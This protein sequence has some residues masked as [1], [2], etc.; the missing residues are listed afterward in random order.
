MSALTRVPIGP[1]DP[2]AVV[3]LS[4]A[5][6]EGP[7]S[8]PLPGWVAWR[9]ADGPRALVKRAIDLA[10]AVA[11]LLLLAPVMLLL[12]VLIRLDS[13]GPALFRQWRRG[14]GGRPFR[15]LK[16]RTMVADAERRLGD[17][18]SDNESAG[19]V[20]FKLRDDPRVTRLGRFLRRS[21]LDELPQLINVLRG[22]MS[23]VGPRPLQLRDCERLAAVDPRGYRHRL[24]VP[25]GLT[26]P[27]QVEGQ[28]ALDYERMVELDCDY[29]VNRSPARDLAI[30][31]RTALVV[32]RGR[33]AP[34]SNDTTPLRHPARDVAASDRRRRHS[35]DSQSLRTVSGI[36]S[37]HRHSVA[38]ALAG[39][40]GKEGQAVDQ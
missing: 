35:L 15:M 10:G 6:H 19:G 25:P 31:A 4:I 13:P 24:Q 27:W 21:S 37:C 34:D 22:E 18:E 38:G 32:L 16:F 9:P 30:I 3:E 23:L 36:T 26:G 8:S 20:L 40:G 29:V 17:L 5:R 11:G 28:S 7:S 33:G 12:A 1:L 39:T 2:A 14:L